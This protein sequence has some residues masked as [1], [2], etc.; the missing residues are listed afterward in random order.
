MWHVS[1]VFLAPLSLPPSSQLIEGITQHTAMQWYLDALYLNHGYYF[2]APDPGPGHLIYYE[3]SDAQ[4]R[5]IKQGHLPDWE[6][7]RPRLWYHR[8]FML[9][10]QVGGPFADEAWQRRYLQAYARQLL[11]EFEGESVR[12]RWI[13]HTPPDPQN[14]TYPVKLDAAGSY[15]ERLPPVVQRRSDLGPEANRQSAA[16]MVSQPEVANRWIGVAR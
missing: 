4:G 14:M 10:E 2:F 15:R 11:R 12:V 1:A 9:A 6:L 13:A 8:H 3:V 7:H 16:P 5:A